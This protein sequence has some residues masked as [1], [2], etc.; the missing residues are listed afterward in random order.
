MA[1]DPSQYRHPP[2]PGPHPGRLADAYRWARGFQPADA[3]PMAVFLDPPYR[4]YEIRRGQMS[5]LIGSL[6]GEAA[7]RVGDRAGGGTDPRRRDPPGHRALGHPPL[8][9]HADRD[10]GPRRRSRRAEAGRHGPSDAEQE[11]DAEAGGEGRCL[12]PRHAAT[13]PWRSSCVCARRASR[14]SGPGGCVRDLILGLTP[15]DY[16][17]ATDATP[18]QVMR[19]LAVPRDHGGDL[20]RRGPGPPS[21]A[22][23][24]SRSRSP[25]SA[26]TAP[27][28][29]AAG[30]TS[31]VFS[32]PE[33]DAARRDFTING[34]FM[35]PE[36]SQVIDYVG[37]LDD[38]REPGPSRHRRPARSGFARTS[39]GCCGPSGS[40]P[41]SA[42][43][44]SRAPGRPSGRW[45]AEVVVVSPERIAQELRRMLVHENRAER[46]GPGARPRPGRGRSSRRWS[47]MKGL[48][49]GKPV[50]PEGDLWDHTLL[51]LRL[52]PPEAELHAGLRRPGPRRGQAVHPL[53]S[54]RADE[55][56]QPRPGGQPDRRPP[57]PEASG[58]PTPSASG[59]PGWWPFIST[60]ARP[61]S[62]ARRS[63]SACWPSPESR[64]CW[65]CTGPTP[66]PPRAT[67]E[68]VD[69]CA[70][71]L[72]N[73]PAGPDQPAAA[74]HRPRPG[75]PRARAG[76]QLRRDPGE[77]PGGPARRPDRQ[78]ARGARVG[79]SLPRHRILARRSG[80]VRCP[81]DRPG[82]AR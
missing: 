48:F 15:A 68:H 81:G 74:A 47:T 19:S 78:Q 21:S 8:R 26:A 32:S 77:D 36:S 6:V 37:G 35:D 40:R 45:P 79:R 20:V 63:S 18:E 1:P 65:R 75:P 71:Y 60:W 76:G 46:H 33:L 4:E 53:E 70:Y 24:A 52:L 62:S 51:V 7:R 28:S 17:V 56:P 10:P 12:R 3:D 16:D 42:S 50:Q 59:S 29:T 27:T 2:V 66:W 14:H 57:V 34:M 55:L 43:R 44:S 49:Q 61:R 13:S 72:E 54:P 41:G 25:R 80:R 30:P 73:Q 58:S 23:R 69:Y 11:P 22:A 31:V 9:R 39:F 67:R 64:S 38:L 5:Q 82:K